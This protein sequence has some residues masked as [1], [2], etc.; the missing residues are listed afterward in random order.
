MH[1][2]QH[3]V[4][5]GAGLAGSLMA[6]YLARRNLTVSVYERRHDIRQRQFKGGRSIN[7]GLSARGIQALTEAG[8]IDKVMAGAVVM[9]GRV[10]HAPDGS[11]TFQAYG[12]DEHEVLHSIDRN[13]LN[14][15]LIDEADQ[16]NNVT[17]YFQ[18][19]C[20]RLD[21][22]SRTLYLQDEQTGETNPIQADVIIGA[23]GAFSV[24]RQ[25]IY[26]GERANYSQEFLHW[27]Y[28]ELTLPAGPDNT[29]LIEHQALHVWPREQG[30]IVSHAN[31]NGSHT[32]T[33]F[34]PFSHGSPYSFD[35]LQT[36]EEILAFFQDWF[37][38]LVP[39]MPD[40]PSQFQQHPTGRLVTIHTDPWYYQDW[41]VLIGDAAH[42]VYPFYGQGMNSAL[43]DCTLLD[44]CIGRLAH[45]PNWATIFQTFQTQRKRHTD[46][47]SQL[48]KQNFIELSSKLKSPL[49]IARKKADILLNQLFPEQWLPIYTMVSHTTIPYADAVQRAQKQ[50]QI[51]K[52][53]SLSLAATTLLAGS[54]LLTR[55]P[56]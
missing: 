16:Y 48:S 25:Q 2:K 15:L 30:L 49:F 47:L 17:F 7:L 1:N 42:A 26:R 3:I 8:L 19:R 40:L 39:L 45:Q 12:K 41:V 35:T 18:Q 5:I 22:E 4:I 50:E 33:L 37:A 11:R 28:K 23:D 29:S 54:K 10:V 6:I 53:G 56:K 52:W 9:R 55:R 31:Q 14:Q 46:T 38:D 20:V 43:E 44:A 32:I 21:K 27:G 51:L 13:E 34:L 36:D 24:V